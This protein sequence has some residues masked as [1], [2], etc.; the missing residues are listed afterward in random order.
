MRLLDVV[1]LPPVIAATAGVTQWLL[2]RNSSTP[3]AS[4]SVV[5][6]A[7]AATGVAVAYGAT[8]VFAPAET[9]VSPL[10]PEEAS[11]LVTGGVFA[12]TR[13]PM[14]LGMALVLVGHAVHRR[15][16]RALLPVAAFVGVIDRFQIAREERALL[17]NFG[18]DYVA[19]TARVPRWINA[20]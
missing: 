1:R 16:V 7:V 17:D 19:Y 14:Y 6:A 11:T 12:R 20:G 9:T 5:G 8:R 10:A 4:T 3:R 18:R 2:T 13:N 15:R